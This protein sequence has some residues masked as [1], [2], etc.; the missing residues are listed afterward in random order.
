MPP[1]SPFE[2]SPI[3][4]LTT[5]GIP[6]RRTGTWGNEF[7][8]R[9]PDALGEKFGTAP[10]SLPPDDLA[11]GDPSRVEGQ[12][13]HVETVSPGKGFQALHAPTRVPLLPLPVCVRRSLV[14]HGHRR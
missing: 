12:A 4:T 7:G 11:G 10:I 3:G 1:H 9:K 2:A 13:P 6:I 14:R 5:P 8:N